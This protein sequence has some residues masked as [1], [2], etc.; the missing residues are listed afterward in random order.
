MQSNVA[1][2][3][4]ST[5]DGHSTDL[6]F[7]AER[8]FDVVL[9]RFLGLDVVDHRFT[10]TG[11]GE[12][13]EGER[14]DGHGEDCEATEV[15]HLLPINVDGAASIPASAIEEEKFGLSDSALR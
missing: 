9:E 12:A 8:V 10:A 14:Q 1:F 13:G 4:T 7:T 15:A 5:P 6:T 2:A 3:L 11:E